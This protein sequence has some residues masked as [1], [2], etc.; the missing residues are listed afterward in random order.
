VAWRDVR[1][2]LWRLGEPPRHGGTRLGQ[3]AGWRRSP[4][5]SCCAAAFAPCLLIAAAHR[6]T[7]LPVP[8]PLQS[9]SRRGSSCWQGASCC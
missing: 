9:L 7:A 4:L 5:Q 8:P 1:R 3:T 6:P 2:L